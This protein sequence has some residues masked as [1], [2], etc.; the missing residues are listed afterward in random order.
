[1]DRVSGT[2]Y[3]SAPAHR[4]KQV[5]IPNCEAELTHSVTQSHSRGPLIIAASVSTLG[6][7]LF[8]YDNIVIS[9]AIGYLSQLFHLDASGTG[10][11]AGCALIGCIA[12]CAFAGTVAD[13]LGKKKGLALCAVCFALSSA[14]MLFAGNLRQFVIWRLIGGVGIGAASV[15]SPNYIAEIA[16]TRVRGRCVT[17]YQLGIVVGI[18]AAV[19]VNM[20]IQRLGDE[21][22]NTSTGWRWMFFAGIVPAL[23]F[24]AMILPAVESPRWLMKMGHRDQA[25]RVLAKVNGPEIADREAE[26]IESSLAIEEGHISELFAAFRRPLFL[27]I[28]LAGLQQ[29]SGITPLFSFLPEIF[30]SAGTATGDAFYQSVL[31]SLVNLLFTLLALWLVDRAGRKTLILAGTTLQFLSFALVGWFYHV[32]GSGLSILIFV[33]SF[34]AGHA[35]GNGVACWVIISEIYPTKVRGRGMSIATTALWLVGYLGNQL[36]PIMRRDLGSDGTFWCFSA[37]ALLTIILVGLLVPETKGRSLE[38]I[39]KFWTSHTKRATVDSES[40]P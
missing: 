25:V 14:G 38:E 32:H 39:T 3:D 19:F 18:L 13:H 21:A 17:L 10:W 23:L 4:P 35:F 34:V 22:W 31:V 40:V 7:L 11:A 26:E 20:L 37:G 30:R 9:G 16:P 6:G 15:I 33:M 5:S 28:M 8:G 29:V 36:F 24:G 2:A 1:M 12:G 27:G